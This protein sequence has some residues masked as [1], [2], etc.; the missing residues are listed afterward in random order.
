MISAGTTSLQVAVDVLQ[1]TSRA[2]DA[3]P[4]VGVLVRRHLAPVKLDRHNAEHVDHAGRLV[5]EFALCVAGYERLVK[6]SAVEPISKVRGTCLEESVGAAAR[7]FSAVGFA[8]RFPAP[9]HPT[10]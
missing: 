10:A 5:V 3:Q 7:G 9:A 6:S 2:T 8:S 1:R 4:S